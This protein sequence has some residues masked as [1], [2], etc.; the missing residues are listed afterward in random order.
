M[1]MSFF[2]ITISFAKSKRWLPVLKKRRSEVFWCDF[3]FTYFIFRIKVR[4]SDPA[5][6]NHQRV[7]KLAV[8]EQSSHFIPLKFLFAFL[9]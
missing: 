7:L 8:R 5:S 9:C 3:F 2:Q 1:D 6:L 4:N